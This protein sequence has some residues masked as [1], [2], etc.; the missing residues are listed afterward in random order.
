MRKLILSIYSMC[1]SMKCLMK[2]KKVWRPV[3]NGTMISAIKPVALVMYV[4][5]VGDH[6]ET[7]VPLQSQE[8][9]VTLNWSLC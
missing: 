7:T 4:P 5:S 6:K 2:S 3:L 8:A 1:H 9:Q